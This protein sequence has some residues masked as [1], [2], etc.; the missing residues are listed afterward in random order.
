[1]PISYEWNTSEITQNIVAPTNGQYWVIATDAFGCISDT[2][3]YNVNDHIIS[4]SAT[5]IQS[6]NIKIFPNPTTGLLNIDSED[7]ITELSMINN[8][9]E[10]VL[11]NIN[12]LKYIKSKI[13]YFKTSTWNVFYTFKSK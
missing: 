11:N 4:S 1:M 2:A 3:F 7:I 13:R 9:G 5:T 12:S 8:I 10:E 6:N